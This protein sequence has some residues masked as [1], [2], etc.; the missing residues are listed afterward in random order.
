MNYLRNTWYVAAWDGE[1]DIQLLSRKL[2]GEQIVFFRDSRG[3]VHAL[4]D[5]CPHRFAPLSLGKLVEG[6]VQCPYHGLRFDGSGA[7]VHNPHGAGTIP[8]AARVKCYPVIERYGAIWIWMGEP[9]AADVSKIPDFSCMDSDRWF[10]G[11]RYLHVKANYLLENDNILDLS[12]IEFLHAETLGGAAVNR[13]IGSIEQKGNTVWAYRQ[14]VAEIM[15]D[16]LYDHMGL[17][18][19]MPVDRWF[20]VRWDPP[21]NLLLLTGATATGRPRSEGPETHFPHLFTPETETTTH[22]WFSA[23]Y[24]K[25]MGPSGAELAEKTV[26][27]VEVPFTRED[28]PMLEQQQ[29]SM[30]TSDLW[31]LKPVLLKGDASAVRAR[32]VLEKMIRE[33]MSRQS[34]II[35]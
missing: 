31:S 20:D 30:G 32:R 34:N 1:V 9:A 4:E 28:L 27:G 14:T 12:H 2:L 35:A 16:F 23:C 10:V 24:P 13:A 22:Y 25:A 17:A 11:K 26:A 5:R 33:E 8:R 15:T 6:V 3:T 7:C 21:S 19:G 29:R 18:R